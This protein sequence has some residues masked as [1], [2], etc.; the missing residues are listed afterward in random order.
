MGL[1]I[2]IA[3]VLL[4]LALGY[5]II[6]FIKIGVSLN[7]YTLYKLSVYIAR[8]CAPPITMVDMAD[9]CHGAS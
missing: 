4:A 6:S 8:H 7:Q 9:F 5:I 3:L 1:D 2:L